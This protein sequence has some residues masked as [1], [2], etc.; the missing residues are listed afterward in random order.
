MSNM[1]INLEGM[2]FVNVTAA[3]MQNFLADARV[4]ELC[5]ESDNFRQMVLDASTAEAKRLFVSEARKKQVDNIIPFPAI[6]STI[7]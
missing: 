5:N 4:A 7:S 1:N 2:G 6:Q 3:V